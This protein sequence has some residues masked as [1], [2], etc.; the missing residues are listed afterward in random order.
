MV[1][2]RPQILRLLNGLNR[3]LLSAI[4]RYLVDNA[5]TAGYIVNQISDY[6]VPVIPR[7]QVSDIPTRKVFDT[8]WQNWAKRA[9][10]TRRYHFND[11]ERLICMAIDAEGDI[12]AIIT[13]E[14]GFPQV[15]LYD[16]FHV[17]TLTGL[18]PKDGVEIDDKTG[19][20][21]GYNVV[22]G[23]VDT[24]T[25]LALKFIPIDQFILLYDTERFMNYRGYAAIRRGSNDLRDAKDIKAF[26]KLKEKFGAAMSAVIQQKG[27]IEEDV[28]GD[29][30]GPQ[31]NQPI[32]DGNNASP[33]QQE[34]KL[35]LAELLGGDIP[36]IDGELKQF[37]ASAIAKSSLD[38][39]DTLDG[40]FCMGLGIPPA[41]FLD[42][43]L[44]GPNVRSVLGKVQRKFNRRKELISRFVE[45]CWLRVMG[46]GIAKGELPAIKG[47]E[48]ISFQFTPVNTIDLGDTMSN[49]RAD[50]LVGQ[51]S[52]TERCGL[53]GLDWEHQH[54]KIVEEITLKLQTVKKL[55]SAF[56]DNSAEQM[57]VIPAILSRFG[58]VGPVNTRLTIQEADQ[59][60]QANQQKAGQ[61]EEKKS[62]SEDEQKPNDKKE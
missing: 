8:Y 43:K 19:V 28:W 34:K 31:G 51:M 42:E 29:D 4:G 47:W 57:A 2:L 61:S 3:K 17:G 26:L 60:T 49:E 21:K 24:V 30:T 32:P 58:L 25:G 44:T 48:Q 14:F 27:P 52:E 23:P 11:I 36:I 53:R 18:D 1:H 10:Y 13:D 38:L 12:G 46:W 45:W 40:Q 22:D 41:F 6:C 37:V 62:G 5:T 56:S 54:Q 50:V 7:S 33:T 55:A 39:L 35:S 59:E 15:K 20:V 16:T 9:D